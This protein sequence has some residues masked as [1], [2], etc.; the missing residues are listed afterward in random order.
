MTENKS[1]NHS[2]RTYFKIIGKFDVQAVVNVLDVKT[3][4]VVNR[5]EFLEH[6]HRIADCDIIEIGYNDSYNVD[7][8][9]MLRVTIEPLKSKIAILTELKKK[10]Q[11]EYYLVAVPEIAVDADEPTPILSLDEDIVEFLYLTKTAHDL[12]YYIY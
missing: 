7:I 2:C 1:K 11:L 10:Y 3:D 12:D 8:N 4:K 5:G 6:L 9:E